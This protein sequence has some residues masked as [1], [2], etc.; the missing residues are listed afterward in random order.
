MANA[1]T[2]GSD[3]QIEWA[4]KLINEEVARLDR[5]LAPIP[6]KEGRGPMFQTLFGEQ[7]AFVKRVRN[8]LTRVQSAKWVIN[9][10]N[11]LF[12]YAATLA[13]NTDADFAA[14][15]PKELAYDVIAQVNDGRWLR[16]RDPLR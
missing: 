14:R 10:R 15:F 7:V 6:V 3:A 1:I 13:R 9:N 11:N 16:G 5:L 12:Y 4:Q 8:I 2:T